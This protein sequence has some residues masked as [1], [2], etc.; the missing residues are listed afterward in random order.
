MNII[1]IPIVLSKIITYKQLS[2]KKQNVFLYFCAKYYTYI[3]L[4]SLF[5]FVSFGFI[6]MMNYLNDKQDFSITNEGYYYFVD[7]EELNNSLKQLLKSG[8][9]Y[10]NLDMIKAR[11]MQNKWIKDLS[12]RKV[13]PEN[14]I[15]SVEE[16]KP[17][18]Y[19]DKN[20]VLTTDGEI[21]TVNFKGDDK[22]YPN[23]IAPENYSKKIIS[24]YE[25]YN[26]KLENTGHFIIQME[27][28]S[29]GSLIF[30]LD[31]KVKVILGKNSSLMQWQR[32]I[33]L[34]MYI[35]KNYKA[36]IAYID[37]RYLNGIAVKWDN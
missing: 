15:V 28:T 10:S 12:L 16:H 7:K 29:Y 27:I 30:V 37:A 17:Y 9:L 21:V 1:V 24:Q 18:A 23:F 25:V 34:Y 36:K 2:R 26:S 33:D 4:V 11:L 32:V 6:S 20:K 22:F 5:L 3:L 14:I 8:F 35:E 31:N 19:W 13:W